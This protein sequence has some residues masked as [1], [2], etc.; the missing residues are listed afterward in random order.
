MAAP[1][2][3]SRPVFHALLHCRALWF[4]MAIT[5]SIMRLPLN[6]LLSLGFL[7][8]PLFLSAQSPPTRIVT[9][10]EYFGSIRFPQNC[11]SVPFTPSA[12][13]RREISRLRRTSADSASACRDFIR[14]RATAKPTAMPP[15]VVVD[16]GRAI[17][18]EPAFQRESAETQNWLLKEVAP[19]KHELLHAFL[20]DTTV[21]SLRAIG[22]QTNWSLL[23]ELPFPYAKT[24]ADLKREIDIERFHK[25]LTTPSYAKLSDRLKDYVAAHL[26]SSQYV[27]TAP[28]VEKS[29][30]NSREFLREQNKVFYDEDPLLTSLARGRS[31][32]LES[33]FRVDGKG[34]SCFHQLN[35]SLKTDLLSLQFDSWWQRERDSWYSTYSQQA[36]S[37]G[38]R[39]LYALVRQ[40]DSSALEFLKTLHVDRLSRAHLRIIMYSLLEGGSTTKHASELDK[41][42]KYF[43]KLIRSE[44][45]VNASSA[46]QTQ[47]LQLSRVPAVGR[48]DSKETFDIREEIDVVLAKA[49]SLT[50]PSAFLFSLAR[51]YDRLRMQWFLS[52]GSP[53]LFYIPFSPFP[54]LEPSSYEYARL[55]ALSPDNTSAKHLD[56]VRVSPARYGVDDAITIEYNLFPHRDFRASLAGPASRAWF[57]DKG[58]RFQQESIHVRFDDN[59]QLL[60]RVPV[61][62][63][64]SNNARPP[65]L[66]MV[67]AALGLVPHKVRTH[68]GD[69][70]VLPFS[71]SSEDGKKWTVAFYRLTDHTIHFAQIE[72]DD[73]WKENFAPAGTMF[74]EFGHLIFFKIL[75]MADKG[76]PLLAEYRNAVMADRAAVSEYGETSLSEDFAEAMDLLQ[77]LPYA[78][79]NDLE[80][81]FD[82]LFPNRKAFFKRHLGSYLSL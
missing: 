76:S 34:A 73:T 30:V 15:D 9:A 47:L 35:E 52:M 17:K 38:E 25:V 75:R 12:M 23:Q 67:I 60:L 39:G 18:A 42:T 55:W 77:L 49:T 71:R 46:I 65:K 59:H 54:L 44:L 74:H 33:I 32:S 79:S 27:F 69:I 41:R 51:F 20:N 61:A 13:E 19:Y 57:L 29:R 40:S 80:G 2:S 5:S 70:F 68:A 82:V 24:L 7:I 10:A 22:P 3:S 48:T 31:S 63:S 4:N 16:A 66:D 72:D 26:L 8:A 36:V 43:A 78:P 21:R 45:F 37:I 56:E 28:L 62:Q 6:L 81:L 14:W 50:N 11:I 53:V 64:V 58:D 1:K